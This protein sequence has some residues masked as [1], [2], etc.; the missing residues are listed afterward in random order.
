M[1]L[2]NEK[3]LTQGDYVYIAIHPFATSEALL[4]TDSVGHQY[5]WFLPW[6]G[7]KEIGP[8]F[9]SGQEHNT[10]VSAY[11]SLMIL[12]PEVS[13]FYLSGLRA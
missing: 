13:F 1:L 9:F 2:A 8:D 11:R 7:D 4:R 3:G 12:M 6:K 10:L 5:I